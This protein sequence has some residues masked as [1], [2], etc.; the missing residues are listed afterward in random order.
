MNKRVLAR[1]GSLVLFTVAAVSLV[2]VAINLINQQKADY[3][4]I[5]FFGVVGVVSLIVAYLLRRF[6]A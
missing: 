6:V 2:I 4:A 3:N 1:G 5:I